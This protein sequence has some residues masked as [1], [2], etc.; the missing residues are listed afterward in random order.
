MFSVVPGIPEDWPEYTV[1]GPAV[2]R[3]RW[4]A[5][6]QSWYPGPYHTFATRT[7]HGACKVAVGG[8]VLARPGPVARRDPYAILS[9]RSADAGFPTD[10]PHPWRDADPADVSPCLT[11]M[12]PYYQTF[13]VGH[14]AGDP[15][16]VGEFVDELVRWGIDTGARSIAFLYLTPAAGLLM[17]ALERAGFATMKINDRADLRVTWTDFDGYLHTLPSKRRIEVRRELAQIHERGLVT[18]ARP[19]ADDEPELVDMRC[20]LIAKYDGSADQAKEAAIFKSIREHVDPADITVLG[21]STGERLVSFSLFIQ[22]DREWTA[23]FA[24]SNYADPGS[25]LGYFSTL[26][27]QP[28][29]LAPARGVDLISYGATSLDAKRRRGCHVTPVYAAALRLPGQRG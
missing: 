24:G 14:R 23:M 10:G 2:S 13:P 25:S 29:A 19:M 5:F 15:A 12:F 8:T 7:E 3:E 17:A 4:V 16:A 1:P 26:F 28:A 18:V 6:G 9:G 22:D 27:Y 20:Q 11:L 21:L